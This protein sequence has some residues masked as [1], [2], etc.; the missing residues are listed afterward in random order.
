ML[1]SWPLSKNLSQIKPQ[2]EKERK[3]KPWR[4]VCP[5]FVLQ[6]R[7]RDTSKVIQMNVT[8][9]EE[10]TRAEPIS[11]MLPP[12]PVL[13][14]PSAQLGFSC[15]FPVPCSPPPP[16]LNLLRPHQAANTPP[17]PLLLTHHS[18]SP[19]SPTLHFRSLNGYRQDFHLHT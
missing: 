2:V 17:L 3:K 5:N 12:A 10:M 1:F 11:E 13:C 15:P 6:A 18:H 14:F 7:L 19:H 8:S 9:G 16:V 4:A